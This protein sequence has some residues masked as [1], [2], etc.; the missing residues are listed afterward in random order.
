MEQIHEKIPNSKIVVMEKAGH[1][2][3]LSKAPEVNQT[4][5]D[6]LNE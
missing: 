5:I 6:F 1:S 3:P 2:S 4:I